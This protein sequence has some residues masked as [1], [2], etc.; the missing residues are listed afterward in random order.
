MFT[1]IIVT[2]GATSAG[3]A[4]AACLV[5]CPVMPNR[6]GM[7][8][9]QLGVGAFI[10]LHYGLSGLHAAAIVSVL[11]AIQSA[12]AL[13]A[14]RFALLQQIGY[15]LI[16]AM[17]ALGIWLWT[18]PSSA[19]AIGAMSVIALARM[20][21]DEVDLRFL[22]LAGTILWTAHDAM[23]GSW[24]PLAADIVT[25]L[26]GLHAVWHLGRR[27]EP[28]SPLVPRTMAA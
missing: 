24:I 16:P 19:L 4:A 27:I 14:H 13:M 28:T 2:H 26:L 18:G 11:G 6:T 22:L 20:Q 7:L 3:L 10:A 21:K 1:E 9:A 25:G 12:A 5:A 8:I 17:I 15:A 23:V